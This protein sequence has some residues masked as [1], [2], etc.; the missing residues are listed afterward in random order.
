MMTTSFELS[1]HHGRFNAWT[2]C[3]CAFLEIG[4][5]SVVLIFLFI[6]DSTCSLVFGP[7]A[8]DQ[9]HTKE[10]ILHN[11]CTSKKSV[12]QYTLPFSRRYVQYHTSPFVSYRSSSEYCNEEG[13]LFHKL[14]S[15][16]SAPRH[17]FCQCIDTNNAILQPK[18]GF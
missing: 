2:E 3:N 7:S 4:C 5:C 10:S 11:L 14:L 8:S 16:D 9:I 15:C 18:R 13:S 6:M 12:S 17:Q 1:S